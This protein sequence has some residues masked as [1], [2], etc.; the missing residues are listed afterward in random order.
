MPRHR[1]EEV[2]RTF[3]PMEHP[4]KICPL[5]TFEELPVGWKALPCNMDPH[6]WQRCWN[7]KSLFSKE[8]VTGLV[9]VKPNPSSWWKDHKPRPLPKVEPKSRRAP[10]EEDLRTLQRCAREQMK[11]RL[12]ADLVFDTQVCALHGWDHREYATELVG[13]LKG[14]AKPEH[15]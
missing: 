2:A 12:L 5:P 13:M 9:R 7:G 6:G 15:R 1:L 11:K 10:T 14:Y 3:E 8:L 4:F